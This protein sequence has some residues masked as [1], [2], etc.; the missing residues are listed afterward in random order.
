[1]NDNNLKGWYF[2]IFCTL[3]IMFA[4]FETAIWK[5]LFETLPTPMI[6]LA[7]L[8]YVS[9]TRPP[10]EVLLLIYT[11]SFFLQTMTVM[12]VGYLILLETS[13]FIGVKALKSRIYW[14][15]RSY[16][17]FLQILAIPWFHIGH[18]SLS[19]MFDEHPIQRFLILSWLGEILS[20]IVLSPIVFWLFTSILP[21]KD[22]QLDDAGVVTHG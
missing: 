16:F 1:M 2:P 17:V 21:L 3:I 22:S 5:N 18:I 13:I 10:V 14:E 7:A 19:Y 4:A 15:G 12:P 11:T 9:I 6:W 8:V 20:F